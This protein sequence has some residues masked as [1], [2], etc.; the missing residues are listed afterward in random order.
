MWNNGF[1]G[2]YFKHQ[3]ND[4]VIAFI[5]GKAKS[6]AFVQVLSKNFSMQYDF[7]ELMVSD[8]EIHV[9]N[10]VFAKHGCRIELPDIRGEI[11]YGSLTPLAYDIMGPF[12][13]L[14][15][16][17]R[18]GVISMTHSLG[19]SIQ[20]G[21][22][23]YS[24]DGGIGYIEKDS[25]VS[26]PRSY[27]W[28]QCNNFPEQCAIMLSVAH[29]PFGGLHFTGCI[30]AIIYGGKEYRLATYKGVKIK[31][32][33]ERHIC[34]EQKNLMLDITVDAHQEGHP[35]RSPVRG[36]MN[37]MIRERCNARIRVILHDGE[38]LIFDLSSD[39]AMFEY[40]PEKGQKQL[41]T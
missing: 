9:G 31:L 39:H 12:C 26:F 10:C 5:P 38:Q 16:Q 30:C 41:G 18:H 4:D 27:L 34:L 33:E 35:L 22:E 7:P 17:C 15:M 25:G 14:P 8:H 37:G 20:I 24:F 11:K 3:I 2:W 13:Y 32:A 40:V 6:G 29:I 23:E 1:E 19:G 21:G 36:K 28:L